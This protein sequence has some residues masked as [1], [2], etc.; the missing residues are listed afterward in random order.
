MNCLPSLHSA[1]TFPGLRSRSIAWVSGLC[2]AAL[3]STAMGALISTD[4]DFTTVY[5]ATVVPNSATP[6]WTLN[7]SQ[8]SASVAGGVLVMNTPQSSGRYYSLSEE[9]WDGGTATGST[10]EFSLKVISTA[11]GATAGATQFMFSTGSK[12]YTFNFSE[13]GVATQTGGYSVSYDTTSD[14]T[15][16]RITLS[17][18]GIASLYAN[19]SSTPLIAD[20]SGSDN[21]NNKISFGDSSNSIGG[22]SHWEYVAFTN[23]G[24][25]APIPEPTSVSLLG[26]TLLLGARL[27]RRQSKR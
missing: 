5:T 1:F 27:C 16:Y 14:F 12:L 10:I 21:S 11:E 24:S 8:G 25:F 22:I 6:K 13:T 2:C 26:V 3:S 18:G 9:T 7:L 20:Y 19:H 15:V 4:V 17:E 23:Q